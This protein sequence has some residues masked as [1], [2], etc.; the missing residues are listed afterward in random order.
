M[1]GALTGYL[2]EFETADALLAA[3]RRVR[4][5]GYRRW[6]CH[7]PF[8]VHGLDAA[9]GIR[10]T[11]LPVV[12]FLCGAAGAALAFLMQWWMNAVDYPLI[13]SGKPLTSL[14]AMLPIIFEL[15]VLLAAIGAFGSVFALSGLPRFH[16]P[17]FHSERFLRATT[18]RFFISVEA[19]DRQFDATATAELLNSLEGGT[20]EPLT[21]EEAP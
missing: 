8:P 13:I 5:A 14:P 11:L 2:V 17:V 12:V 10:P 16:H 3:A 19:A 18:D 15:M 9:M 4:D 6:D 21:E 7:T 20:V 1:S